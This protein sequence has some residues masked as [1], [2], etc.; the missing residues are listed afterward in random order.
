MKQDG[1]LI[2]ISDESRNWMKTIKIE[3]PFLFDHG[4]LGLG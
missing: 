3:S 4:W 2:E 1:E